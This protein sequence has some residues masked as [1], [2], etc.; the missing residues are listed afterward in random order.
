MSTWNDLSEVILHGFMYRM[1]A[2]ETW[3]EKK[4]YLLYEWERVP[5]PEI[6]NK[7][8]IRHCWWYWLMRVL[9]ER[10]V[11]Q[12]IEKLP[13]DEE[14][15]STWYDLTLQPF[16]RAYFWYSGSLKGGGNNYYLHTSR[17]T[18]PRILALARVVVR[19][20]ASRSVFGMGEETDRPGRVFQFLASLRPRVCSTT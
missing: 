11:G 9:F 5:L 12:T 17:D 4:W 14:T 3:G 13:I 15:E 18:I 2:R 6:T 8:N 19:L 10:R 1:V 7:K 20:P 16:E